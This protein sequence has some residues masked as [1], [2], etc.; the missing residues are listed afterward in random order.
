M[1]N[2]AFDNV[3]NNQNTTHRLASQENRG[4]MF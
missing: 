3:L 2:F 4:N 1:S